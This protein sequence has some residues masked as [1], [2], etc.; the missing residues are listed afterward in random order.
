MSVSYNII[1][2]LIVSVLKR[3][4]EIKD[5]SALIP[6]H[7]GILDRMDSFIFVFLMYGLFKIIIFQLS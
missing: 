5:S 3:S 2:Y 4:V 6:G 7:G 1:S